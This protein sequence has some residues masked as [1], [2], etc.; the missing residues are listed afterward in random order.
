MEI[1]IFDETA[2][3]DLQALGPHGVFTNVTRPLITDQLVSYAQEG[4][5]QPQLRDE[6]AID[7]IQ[8]AEI[9]QKKRSD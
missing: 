4:K 9:I 1:S 3:R 7:E 5:L 8:Q 2:Q 6:K